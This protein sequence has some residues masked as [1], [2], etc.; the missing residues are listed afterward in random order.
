MSKVMLDVGGTRLVLDA[1]VGFEVFKLLADANPERYDY[2][3]IPKEQSDTGSSKHLYYVRPAGEDL[4]L[5]VV[6]AE[7]YAI[8]KLYASTRGEGK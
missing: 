5:K 7:D 6:N 1:D 3:W 2:D 4:T 8:W